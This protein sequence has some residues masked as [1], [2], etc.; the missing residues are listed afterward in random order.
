MKDIKYW[1][2]LSIF[3]F[4]PKDKIILIKLFKNN[5]KKIFESKKD[6][7]YNILI[8]NNFL[9]KKAIN[10]CEKIEESKKKVNLENFEKLL[11]DNNVEVIT[12]IDERYPKRLLNIY[13]FP[14]VLYVKGNTTILNQR[15]LAI[16]GCR[17]CT[18]YGKII[19]IRL[20]RALAKNN[21]VIISGLARGIDSYSHIGCILEKKPTIAV[22]GCGVD[23][24]YP[25]EN[26]TVYDEILK[27]NG[28]I[29]SE[30]FLGEEPK[31][32]HFPM[33]NRII[34]G[35]SDGVAVV[36]A[37]KQSGSLIT[38]NLALE[39]GKEVY[40]FP[41]DITKETSKGTNELIKDGAKMVLSL[42]DILEDY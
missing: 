36:E 19:S 16:C 2:W 3:N 34:S 20:S 23:I 26:K 32:Y 27:N 28:A 9:A 39:Q 11:K 1:V 6:D 7:L 38:A 35:M 4:Q 25:K 21:F 14:I 40:A 33:R 31:K 8:K 5:P 41:G 24:V 12:Y 30:Y 37:K 17:K 42:D 10:I 15:L 18:S 29:I 22:L 13:D